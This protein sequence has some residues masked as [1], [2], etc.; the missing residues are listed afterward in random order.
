M[1]SHQSGCWSM[2]GMENYRELGRVIHRAIGDSGR[3]LIHFIGRNRPGTFSPWI[4][5]RIFP[6]AY[7]PALREMTG[8]P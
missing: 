8:S 6:G 7:T 1:F 4:R 2:L 5:K 3:G